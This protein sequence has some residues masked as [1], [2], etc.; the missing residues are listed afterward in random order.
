M[1]NNSKHRYSVMI[2]A[3]PDGSKFR[4]FGWFNQVDI[5]KM[6]NI[7]TAFLSRE[8]NQNSITKFFPF[9][10]ILITFFSTQES[11]SKSR[12]SAWFRANIL[13]FFLV[14]FSGIP[15]TFIV[16]LSVTFASG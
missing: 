8:L 11:C 6:Y 7:Q 4:T 9:S 10:S 13:V 3:H 15:G 1:D 14:L 2:R 5:I 16:V 12:L